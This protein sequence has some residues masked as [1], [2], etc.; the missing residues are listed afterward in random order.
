MLFTLRN[1]SDNS[2]CG[3][4]GVHVDDAAT[5]GEGALFRESIRK[6]RETI[7]NGEFVVVSL[8]GMV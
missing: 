4:M 7:E 6:L 8:W 2:L 3:V 1:A 5:G